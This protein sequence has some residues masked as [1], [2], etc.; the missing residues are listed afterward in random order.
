MKRN[1][2]AANAV[3]RART[4]KHPV[5]DYDHPA[6]NKFGVGPDGKPTSDNLARKVDFY[7]GLQE[8]LRPSNFDESDLRN[9]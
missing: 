3:P 1:T 2:E 8:K 5:E 7:P 4:L 6:C 9:Y